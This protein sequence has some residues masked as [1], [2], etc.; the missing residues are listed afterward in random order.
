MAD[1]Q[2]GFDCEFVDKPPEI[3]QSECPVCLLILREP[4][5]ATCCG[6]SFCRVCIERIKLR[7][8]PCPCCKAGEFDHYPNKGLQRSLYE[9]KA[10]CVNKDQGCE[11]VGELGQLDNHLNSKP[12]EDKQLQGCQFVEIQCRYCSELYQRHSIE[13]HQNEQCPKRSF[14]CDYCGDFESTYEDV[15]TNHWPVCSKYLVPCPNNCGETLQHQIVESHTANECP[16]TA[17]ECTFKH[18]GCKVKLPRKDM[19]AHLTESIVSHMSLH[20]ASFEL[21]KEENEQLK[22][23][24][25]RLEQDVQ[26][27][28]TESVPINVELV[29][30][31]VDQYKRNDEVWISPPFYT[32]PHGYKMCLKVYA[33]GQDEAKG[34]HLSAYIYVLQGEYDS[35]LTWPFDGTLKLSVEGI[36]TTGITMPFRGEYAVNRVTDSWTSSTGLGF[37]KLISHSE[38]RQLG[39]NLRFKISELSTRI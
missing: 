29:M 30:P 13:A 2:G 19:P 10:K 22:K 37:P 8:I 34:T 1:I 25:A 23:Q 17:I 14:S 9:F 28:K 26:M 7:N 15:T 11:W 6:Y 36:T 20:V 18:V 21:L 3:V 32:H 27:L 16:L 38:L 35:I 4:Y 12:T 5:Q 33:N 31:N 39:N 24:V